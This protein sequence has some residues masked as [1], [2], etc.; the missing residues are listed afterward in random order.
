MRNQLL[1]DTDWASIA[2]SL[3]VR[4]PLVDAPI[5]RKSQKMPAKRWLVASPTVPLPSAVLDRV[6]T[7]FFRPVQAWLQ[8][9][10]RL[11]KWRCVPSFSVAGYP[12]ARRWA[13]QVA[14]G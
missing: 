12:W 6:K 7:E 13:Y 4:A 5:S 3:E 11:H 9:D 10:E 1:R 8:Q 14:R 2:H